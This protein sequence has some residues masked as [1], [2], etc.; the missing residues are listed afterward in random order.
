M[1][2]K[3]HVPVILTVG[4]MTLAMQAS[5]GRYENQGV[6]YQEHETSCV[7]ADP[8]V[9]TT[10]TEDVF[11]TIAAEFKTEDAERQGLDAWGFRR[12]A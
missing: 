2:T 10:T 4:F 1:P 9:A 6:K 3:F 5:T 11:A 8:S 7:A 12:T